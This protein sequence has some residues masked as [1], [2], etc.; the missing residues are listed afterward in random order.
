MKAIDDLIKKIGNDKLLHFLVGLCISAVVLLL[1][2]L[3]CPETIGTYEQVYAYI[4]SFIIVGFLSVVKEFF[5]DVFDEEDIFA[6]EIGAGI[7]I[8]ISLVVFL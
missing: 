4:V 8:L 5:D 7:P 3:L 2:F 6:A 1:Y